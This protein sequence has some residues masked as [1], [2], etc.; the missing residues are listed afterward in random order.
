MRGESQKAGV[1]DRL[2][3]VVASHYHFHVVVKTSRRQTFKVFEGANVFAEGGREILRLY[4]AQILTARVTQHVTERMHP[5]PPFVR[6]RDVVRRIIHLS[7]NPRAGFKALHRSFRRVGANDAQV[8]FHDAVAA[9]KA[10]PPQF[11]MQADGGQIRIAFQQLDDLVHIRVQQAR[12]ARAVAFRF[13]SSGSLVLLQHVAHAFAVD[14]Q[15]QRDGSLRSTG[16]VQADNLVAQRFP[17]AAVFISPTRS[18]L[19]DATDAASRDSFSK[20]DVKIA[21]SS[22]VS[23]ARP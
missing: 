2:V 17:H 21:R 5:P 15:L 3:A 11:F 8:F 19:N 12:P 9:L 7:L 16:I 23:P 6:E 22:G 14:S 20:R 4:E 1:V 13:S 18:E 10:Q